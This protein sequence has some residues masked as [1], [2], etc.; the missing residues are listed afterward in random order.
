ML[1]HHLGDDFLVEYN[2]S[3]IFLSKYLLR[4]DEKERTQESRR[5]LDIKITFLLIFVLI[6]PKKLEFFLFHDV[7]KH[8]NVYFSPTPPYSSPP[9]SQQNWQT[10]KPLNVKSLV[11]YISMRML[12]T[13]RDICTPVSEQGTE[14]CSA[15]LKPW[16]CFIEFLVF[17]SSFQ[18]WISQTHSRYVSSIITNKFRESRDH[19][20]ITS[21]SFKALNR[22]PL[23]I[24]AIQKLLE[25]R[26][27]EQANR[28][29][30]PP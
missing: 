17:K 18:L 22:A 23:H 10:S 13:P 2:T 24:A 6:S 26:K 28:I 4:A 1:W 19:D 30:S 21:A 20:V 14:P 29:R 12:Y 3:Q 27:E 5:R 15:T 11:L 7:F 16:N 8:K 9:K 25:G